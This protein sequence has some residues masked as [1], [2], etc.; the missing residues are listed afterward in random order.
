MSLMSMYTWLPAICAN[1]RARGEGGAPAR[2][3][4]VREA[5]RVVVVL[6]L[7][8]IAVHERGHVAALGAAHA[9]GLAR[10]HLGLDL[11]TARGVLRVAVGQDPNG[12][13]R[14]RKRG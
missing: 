1:R 7:V 3:V 10:L 2:V 12:E 14:A 9:L 13:L 11:E 6:V 8:P 5:Q 4:A